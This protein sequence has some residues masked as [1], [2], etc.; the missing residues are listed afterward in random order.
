MGRGERET[1]IQVIT[2][3][4]IQGNVL[5]KLEENQDIIVHIKIILGETVENG[6]ENHTE[7]MLL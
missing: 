4:S 7:S 6:V 5:Y 2:R 1:I 3:E